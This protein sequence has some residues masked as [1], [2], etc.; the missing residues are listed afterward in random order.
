MEILKGNKRGYYRRTNYLKA[1][2]FENLDDPLRKR[3]INEFWYTRW[4]QYFKHGYSLYLEDMKSNM[5]GSI[6]CTN[7]VHSLKGGTWRFAHLPKLS[8]FLSSSSFVVR[9]NLLHPWTFFYFTFVV[10]FCLFNLFFLRK[11]LFKGFL[12][13]KGNSVPGQNTVT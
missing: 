8:K 3:S 6:L 4:F 2:S 11:L 5:R 12:Q 1:T 13:F 9:V 10:Y 7:F